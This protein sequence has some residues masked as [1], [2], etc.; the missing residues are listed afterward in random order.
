MG[1]PGT[2]G[3]IM[4][5][6]LSPGDWFITV[7]NGTNAFLMDFDIVVNGTPCIT[8]SPLVLKPGASRLTAAGFQLQWE[9]SASERYQV[10]YTETLSPVLWQTIT[11]VITS[12]TG[13]FEF[14]DSTA[15]T[16]GAGGQRFYRLLRV[17]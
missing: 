2:V 3:P 8:P 12:G 13:H 10:Q 14:L 15:P 11:N 17:P 6:F 1:A 9:A 5:P 4:V 16:N 7:D